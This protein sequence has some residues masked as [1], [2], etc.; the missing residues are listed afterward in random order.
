MKRVD[1]FCSCNILIVNNI[2]QYFAG[3]A[4]YNHYW[5]LVLFL[6]SSSSWLNHLL[7][8]NPNGLFPSNFNFYMAW[9]VDWKWHLKSPKWSCDTANNSNWILI[10]VH[11]IGDSGTNL[12]NL[13]TVVKLFGQKCQPNTNT[14][15]TQPTI[16]T[17]CSSKTYIILSLHISI[18]IFLSCYCPNH[19]QAT[20]LRFFDHPQLDKH[21]RYD[22]SEAVISPLWR[23][24]LTQHKRRM[25]MKAARFKPMIPAI[26]QPDLCL[27]PCGHWYQLA[28]E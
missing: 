21:I 13:P 16:T 24:L 5:L 15:L 26:E 20:F 23:P 4:L 6:M 25:S 11:S 9:Q 7:L 28:W 17:T 27:R 18:I 12:Y 22:S 19:T 14:V 10:T 1:T 8:G 2:Q 3:V